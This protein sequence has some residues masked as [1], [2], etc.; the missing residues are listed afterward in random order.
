MSKRKAVIRT[1][2]R[3]LLVVLVVLVLGGFW[4][5]SKNVK[6]M[7]HCV[8]AVLT[9]LNKQYKVTPVD[10]GDYKAMKIM[11]PAK[12]H[13]EQYQIE[14]LGNLS[15]MRVNMGIMQMATVVITPR[16]K[17][18]PLLSADY[19]YIL[20]NRKSYM[21]FYDVVE[22][23]DESYQK[24][25]GDLTQAIKKYEHLE[26]IEVTPA[27]YEHL[28]T[29]TAYKGGKTKADADLEG[30]LVD[31]VKVYLEHAKALPLLTE[32]EKAKKKQITMEYTDGLI[33]K[34]GISTDVF[35]KKLGDEATKKFFDK[36]FFGTE[37][38]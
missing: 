37:A 20:G 1:V 28:L 33:A 31:S 27:W 22:E 17:N 16:D 36:V 4:V 24:L 25:L 2:L 6:A 26:N 19:M 13:V 11:G 23:K 35:K 18:M 15:V 7:N 34:G 32:E 38:E 3:L 21:E 9:E 29:V 12:F 10:V 5:M 14:E 30:M 8:D